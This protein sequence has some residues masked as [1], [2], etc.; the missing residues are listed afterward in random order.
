MELKRYKE[1]IANQLIHGLEAQARRDKAIEVRDY[2]SKGGSMHRPHYQ[3][4]KEDFDELIRRMNEFKGLKISM[5]GHVTMGYD[6]GGGMEEYDYGDEEYDGGSFDGNERIMR[7]CGTAHPRQRP[8]PRP[9]PRAP[10]QVEEE[11]DEA[12][13]DGGK[14]HFVKSMKHLGHSMKKTGQEFGTA[15]KKAGINEASKVI[16]QEGVKFAKDNIGKMISG[17]EAIAPEALPV[18]EEAAPLMLMAAGMKKPKRT[19]TVSEKEKRRHA[20][21]WQ[22]MQQHGCT[23]GEASRHIKEEG[24]SY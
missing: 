1:K 7:K 19:R 3:V 13:Y 9:R 24:L 14:F 17:A 15:L 11:E 21:V 22:L 5:P 23:L 18:A 10:K 20:L 8:R 2:S 6:C 16:A 4:P 12:E